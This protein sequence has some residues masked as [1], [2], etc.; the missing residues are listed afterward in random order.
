MVHTAYRQISEE[1]LINTLKGS[2][3]AN[4]REGFIRVTFTEGDYTGGNDAPCT[5]DL[6]MAESVSSPTTNETPE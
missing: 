5:F 4:Q 2:A 6:M 1:E 3:N